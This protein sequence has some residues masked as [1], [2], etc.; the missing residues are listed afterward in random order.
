MLKVKRF[1]NQLMS[2]NCFVVYDDETRKAVVIDPGSEKS[3]Q[4]ILFIEATRLDVDYIILTHEHTDHNWGV[5]ALKERYPEIKLV[6]SELCDKLV[7]KTNRIFFSFYYDNPDYVYIIPTADILIKSDEDVL[8]WNGI[9]IH[10]VMTPGHS[11]ASMCIDINGMLFTG[12]TIMPFPRY[13]NRKD[14]NEEDWKKSV[15][16]IESLYSKDTILYPGHGDTLSLGEWIDSPEYI[17]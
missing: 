10:F 17:Q 16:L 6:C 3:E 2:S 14:G 15:R 5:N 9:D 12:D 4:E 7:K 8:L 1:I 13:L 11:K